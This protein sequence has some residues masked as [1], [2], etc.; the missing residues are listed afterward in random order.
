MQL[1]FRIIKLLNNPF[2]DEFAFNKFN[3]FKNLANTIFLIFWYTFLLSH[4]VWRNFFILLKYLKCFRVISVWFITIFHHVNMFQVKL[5]SSTQK[6]SYHF[7]LFWTRQGGSARGGHGRD[8][9]LD[10][11]SKIVNKKVLK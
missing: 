4:E 1:C 10:I 3:H 7:S 5:I 2:L 11:G 6:K 8:C 9:P